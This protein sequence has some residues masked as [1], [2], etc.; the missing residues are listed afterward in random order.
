MEDM[1]CLGCKNQ[2]NEQL[3]IRKHNKHDNH[4]ILEPSKLVTSNL[5]LSDI[6]HVFTIS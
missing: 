4:P 2:V 6:S 1:T 5:L 3:S